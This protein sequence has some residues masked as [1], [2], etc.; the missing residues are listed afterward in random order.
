MDFKKP[1]LVISAASQ[2]Q[3]PITDL[4]EVLLCGRS[5]VGKSSFIN[6]MVRRKRLAY[7]AQ[8]PGKT[9]LLNFYNL[10]DKLMFVDA[11]GYGF[12]K[13][14]KS[15]YQTFGKLMDDYIQ[16]RQNLRLCILLLDIRRIPNADDL[17]MM[18]Y[19]NHHQMPYLLIL[20]KADKLSYSQQLKQQ[21]ML[22]S[23][24]KTA[25]HDLIMFNHI[26]PEVR[27]KVWMKISDCL[28]LSQSEL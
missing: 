5:N 13:E 28:G 17:M 20:T 10:D 16:Q 6:T 7:V 18:D 3:W 11:P 9:R 23:V 15:D 24:L 27:E 8:T 25:A 4:P 14:Q 2:Q 1:Y 21:N 12:Q 26:Q 22:A 19:F